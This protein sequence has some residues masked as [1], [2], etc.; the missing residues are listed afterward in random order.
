MITGCWKI[1]GANEIGYIIIVFIVP[2][3]HDMVSTLLS[4]TSPKNISD[5]IVL[6]FIALHFI[7]LLVL[8]PSALRINILLFAFL[9]WRTSYNVGIGA[10][11]HIQS[12]HKALVYWARNTGIFCA[13][14]KHPMYRLIKQEMTA[15][16]VDKDYNFDKAP[17]EFNTWLVFRRL[18]DLVLMCD[19]VSYSLFAIACMRVPSE[20]SWAMGLG[21]W[22]GGLA[23]IAFNLWVKLDAHR[24]V[25][26][27]AWCKSLFQV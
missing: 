18:V 12:N 9:F 13:E 15:K 24:V 17:V 11:L 4:P 6:G 22:L 16:I 23:L 21:R 5:F 25:K 10:L 7:P 14:T 8:P 2:Q 19:F 27:Y 1:I 20:E 3:T 26:D